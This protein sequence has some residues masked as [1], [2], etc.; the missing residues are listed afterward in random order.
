MLSFK[1]LD[2][3]EISLSLINFINGKDHCVSNI[4]IAYGKKFKKLPEANCVRDENNRTYL[5]YEYKGF[6]CSIIE[7]DYFS[8]TYNPTYYYNDNHPHDVLKN[9]VRGTYDN[10]YLLLFIVNSKQ[11]MSKLKLIL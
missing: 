7:M 9:L 3:S 4:S 2:F 11:E 1:K 6:I 5:Q 8:L 10:F